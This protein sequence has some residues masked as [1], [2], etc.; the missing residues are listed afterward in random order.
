ME[1]SKMFKKIKDKIQ[2]AYDN[3]KYYLNE[4]YP[5]GRSVGEAFSDAF[6]A[7]GGRV[8]WAYIILIGG[9]CLITKQRAQLVL[10]KR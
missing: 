5:F 2:D 9:Y 10:V 6:F 4:E 3:V 8:L 7:G 1:E